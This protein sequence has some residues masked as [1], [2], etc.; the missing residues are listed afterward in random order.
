MLARPQS[1]RFPIKGTFYY[2]AA[3][4]FASNQL[5]PNSPLSIQAEPDNPYDAHA[6]K[7]WFNDSLLGYVPKALSQHWPDKVDNLSLF[8]IQQHGHF[9]WLECRLS[10]HG[11]FSTQIQLLWLATFVRWQYRLKLWLLQLTHRAH[12]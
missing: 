1:L 11:S 6:L 12:P 9:L 7:I 2:D 8:K 4:C 10:Y 5:Q 3:A